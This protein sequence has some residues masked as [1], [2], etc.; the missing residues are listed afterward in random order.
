M[1][2][3]NWHDVAVV[4]SFKVL[5]IAGIAVGTVG[6]GG[7]ALVLGADSRR[8]EPTPVTAQVLPPQPV[9]VAQPKP[10]QATVEPPRPARSAPQP[11]A[12]A[13]R[14]QGPSTP[15]RMANSSTQGKPT[16]TSSAPRLLASGAKAADERDPSVL[17]DLG[18]KVLY[19]GD[20]AGSIDYFERSYAID[21]TSKTRFAIATAHA[22]G[23]AWPIALK[24]VK[25]LVVPTMG[26]PL[27]EKVQKLAQRIRTQCTEQK[28]VC[29]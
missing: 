9:P 23:G 10:T 24:E 26:T 16:A 28:I 4:A 22:I 15:G 11:V 14:A 13:P 18:R 7:A 19:E 25:Q 2:S 5:V 1:F 3:H 29:E 6:G 17:Y 8:S 21:P 27:G 12:P 20:I